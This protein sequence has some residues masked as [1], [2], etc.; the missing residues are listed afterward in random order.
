[1]KHTSTLNWQH[2]AAL[3]TLMIL[4][5]CGG[6]GSTTLIGTAGGLAATTHQVSGS[7]SGLTANGLVL[8]VNGTTLP[9]AA[10]ATTF[11]FP[12][13]VTV[14]TS[15]AITVATQPTGQTCTVNSGTGTIGTA[16]VAN[17]VVTCAK[18]AY[19]LGG[20]VNGLN[21]SGLVL[22]NGNDTVTVPA[23]ATTFTLPTAVAYGASYAVTVK[24]QPAGLACAVTLG[25]GTMPASAISAVVVTCTDQTF[26]LSAGSIS[27]LATSGLTLS[28]NGGTPV[29]VPANTTTF[30]LPIGVAYGSS[31]AVTVATQPTGLTCTVTNG[32]GTMPAGNVSNIGITCADNAYD[33]GGSISGLTASGLVLAFGSDSVSVASGATTFTLPTAVAYGSSYAV[34]ITSQPTG[35]TCTVSNGTGTMPAGAVTNVAVT[36]AATTYTLGG[37]LTGVTTTGLTLANGSDTLN[38]AANATVFTLPAGVAPGASYNVTVQAHPAGQSCTVSTN[39]SG[40]MPSS[41]VTS[42]AVICVAGSVSLFYPFGT[43]SGQDGQEPYGSLIQGND[44]NFYGLTYGGGTNNDGTVFK[45]TP[46][47]VETVLYSFGAVSHD[48][49]WPYGNLIQGNDGNFYGLTNGGGTNYY[50]TVFKITP[51]GVETVLYSFGAV[52]HD[53]QEPYGSLIQAS[54]GNLYGMTESGGTNGTGT[55]FKIVTDGTVGGTTESVFYSFG[56]SGGNDGESPYYGSLIQASDGNFYGMTQSGGTNSAGILFKITPAGVETVLYTFGATGIDA[57]GPYGSLIQA[58]DGNFYGMTYEGGTNDDGTVFKIVTD[59]T[60]GGTTESVLHSFG[61]SNDGS[62]PYGSLIQG[63]DGNFYGMTYEG[64]TNNDGTVF[65]ITPAGVES[66]VYSFGSVSNDGR[67]P[68][69]SLI[70]GNDGNFYG[71]TYGGGVDGDGIVFEIN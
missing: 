64:G 34:T 54:D 53:G 61:S 36:C 39:G 56:H 31:Y 71:M 48:G 6:S 11:T 46:A 66:V 4:S 50:G 62:E 13:P 1:M 15:Y 32:T 63:N 25:S 38:V 17:A 8:S 33:L 18:N 29:A 52:S 58:S 51:A 47:G 37:T 24:T 3:A 21:G 14:G 59:G 43:S 44:G 26:R 49:V 7:V 69:G 10:G 5:A 16:N 19:S 42:I 57:Y 35:H 27:G 9:V 60:V 70:Q 45:I 65:K 41:D 67:G 2:A 20:T 12:T 22:A 23:N 28:V 40:T 68:Y 30:S 55:V